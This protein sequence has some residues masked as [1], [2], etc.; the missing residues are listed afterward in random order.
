MDTKVPA[1]NRTSVVKFFARSRGSLEP[2]TPCG[3][4]SSASNTGYAGKGPACKGSA[5]SKPWPTTPEPPSPLKS[6]SPSSVTKRSGA[7]RSESWSPSKPR[8]MGVTGTTGGSFFSANVP[9]VRRSDAKQTGFGLQ[10]LPFEQAVARH[11]R[12]AI[13]FETAVA[14]ELKAVQRSHKTYSERLQWEA[15]DRERRKRKA[16]TVCEPVTEKK[17][18][19][20]EEKMCVERCLESSKAMMERA[21]GLIKMELRHKNMDEIESGQVLLAEANASL[22]ANMAKL[23]TV[24]EKLQRL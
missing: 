11:T 23:A 7:L 4:H 12:A 24:N 22:S 3:H 14:F 15:E 13:S 16:S 18:K 21:Q 17:I 10:R 5:S 9:F 8:N 2:K 19:L 6:L 20:G 1:L